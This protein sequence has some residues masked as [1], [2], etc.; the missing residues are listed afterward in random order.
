MV[1]PQADGLQRVE[2]VAVDPRKEAGH[3]NSGVCIQELWTICFH[4]GSLTWLLA[5]GP[6]PSRC[7]SRCWLP[8]YRHN[9]AASSPGVSYPKS[10]KQESETEV[11]IFCD[12]AWEVTSHHFCW[13]LSVTKSRVMQ[14][15]RGMH[16][17]PRPTGG[18]LETG[19]HTLIPGTAK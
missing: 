8:A 18:I 15:Q 14:G 6:R 4:N 13:M 9:M 16:E 3:R 12:P 5:G 2:N 10:S 17:E 11:R 19:H 7:G 1:H